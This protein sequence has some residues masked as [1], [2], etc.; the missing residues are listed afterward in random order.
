MSQKQPA[1]QPGILEIDPYIP[2]A[3]HLPSG[4]TPIKLSSNETP[5]GPSP[6]ALQAYRDAADT[7]ERYPDGQATKLREAI[8]QVHGLNADQI[9]CGAGSDELLNLLAAA[10]LGP[11]DEAIYS[12]HGF[13]VYRIA[14][15]ANGATP[16]I[17]PETDLTT[18]VDAILAS[19]TPK[20]RMVFVANPNNPTGS[21]LP[22]AEVERLRAGL[23]DDIILVLDGAYAEYVEGDAYNDRP[24][25]DESTNKE[26]TPTFS[27]NHGLAALRQG[28]QYAPQA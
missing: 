11:G 28:W 25:L 19:V 18:D 14:I 20:T 6:A 17:A 4:R 15:L 26:M 12:E 5:L 23:P 24:E 13:L 16:V 2:G 1:P 21:V 7:L 27:K 3:S 10:Y 9:I 22:A 8:A